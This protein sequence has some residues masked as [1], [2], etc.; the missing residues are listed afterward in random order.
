M[1]ENGDRPFLFWDTARL[2]HKKTVFLKKGGLK[3]GEKE[4]LV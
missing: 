2:T 1:K 3:Y 4:G